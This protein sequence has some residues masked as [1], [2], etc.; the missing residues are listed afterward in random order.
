M[1]SPSRDFES[2][3]STN[4]AIPAFPYSASN[5]GQDAIITENGRHSNIALVKKLQ[6]AS[7]QEKIRHRD[8][9]YQVDKLNTSTAQR[10]YRCMQ[11]SSL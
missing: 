1:K 4:S 7:E 11:Y 5:F 3:A 2:R 8:A 6:V 9:T 10:N